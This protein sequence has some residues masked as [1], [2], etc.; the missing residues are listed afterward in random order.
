[1]A[2]A[3]AEP[4]AAGRDARQRVVRRAGRSTT[5]NWMLRWIGVV[6]GSLVAERIVRPPG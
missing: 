2:A 5:V 3:A 6:A 1:M 4:I